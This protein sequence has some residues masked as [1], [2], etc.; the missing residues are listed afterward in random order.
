VSTVLSTTGVS[1]PVWFS[2]FPTLS[3]GSFTTRNP[4]ATNLTDSIL[5]ATSQFRSTFFYLRD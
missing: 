1:S 3:T 5:T 4:S 2:V